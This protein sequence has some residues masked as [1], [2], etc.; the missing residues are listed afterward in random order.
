[1]LQ[2]GEHKYVKLQIWDTAGKIQIP[3]IYLRTKKVTR[4]MFCNTKLDKVLI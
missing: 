4:K 1:M 2:L 3:G